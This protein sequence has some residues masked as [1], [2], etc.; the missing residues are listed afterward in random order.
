MSSSGIF[1]SLKDKSNYDEYICPSPFESSED[2]LLGWCKEAIQQGNSY[3]RDQPAYNYIQTGMDIVAGLDDTNK[4][5]SLSDV[6]TE[7]TVRNLKEVIAAQT[8]IR[9]IP[10]FTTEVKQFNKQ[11]AVLNKLYMAWQTATFSDRAIRKVWQYASACGTGYGYM[12]YD[13]NFWRKGMGDINFSAFGPM[14][15]IPIGVPKDH[16]LQKA[17]AVAVKIV[18]PYH[19]AV[20]RWGVDN[21]HKLIP[22]RSTNKGLS[23]IIPRAV[24]YASSALRR[25]G[26]GSTQESEPTSW[27]TVDIYYMYVDDYTINDK[28]KPIQMGE[29]GTSWEYTVPPKKSRIVMGEKDGQPIYRDSTDDDCRLFPTR[30]LICFTENGVLNPDMDEQVSPYWYPGVPV[31]QFRADDWP[32]S[33]LGFPLTRS[34]SSLEKA[35]NQILRGEVDAVNARLS[36]PIGYDNTAISQ[37]L[38]DSFNPRIPNQSLGLNMMLGGKQIDPLLP[39]DYY[40]VP[41]AANEL[42]QQNEGRIKW[43]MGVADAQALAKARQLPSGDSLERIMDSLGPLIKDQSR[44]MEAAIRS[45]GEMWKSFCFQFYDAPRRFQILGETGLV[46]EDYDYDPGQLVPDELEGV[47]GDRFTRARHHMDHFQFKVTPY[48]LHELNSVTRKLFHLQLQ[49]AGF[50][51]DWWTLA[52]I[53]DIKN[54]G[55]K[56]VITD[57]ETQ[58]ERQAETVIECW[59]AQKEIEVRMAQAM[60]GGGGGQGKGGGRPPSGHNAPTMDMK[61][62][63]GGRPIIRESKK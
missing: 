43:Q 27:A 32:W 24:K 53:F 19:E 25:F 52:D 14:D 34:G 45:M 48:S 63:T 30:R 9:V 49:R 7:S 23:G 39:A 35:N 15:I 16:D 28:S 31:V 13:P 1:S 56:P 17:Y 26:P 11:S 21:L 4:N 36:P 6:R 50:P 57:P 12:T 5:A 29:E 33:F 10:V 41:P 40:S 61:G 47:E 38:A 46:E 54:F 58:E 22:Q 60:G 55:S 37:S 42:V 20:R 59:I 2:Y 62:G 44:N 8:N 3:L 51:L 18:T